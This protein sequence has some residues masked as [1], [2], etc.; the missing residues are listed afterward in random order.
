MDLPFNDDPIAQKNENINNLSIPLLLDGS[1]ITYL[2][3]GSVVNIIYIKCTIFLAKLLLYVAIGSLK[4]FALYST[5]LL[6]C[7]LN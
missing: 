4:L 5:A 1:L 2:A 6:K 7:I 3:Y